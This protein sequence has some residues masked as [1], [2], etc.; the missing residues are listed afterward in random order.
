[1]K[2]PDIELM[3]YTDGE[4]DEERARRVRV[5]RLTEL[6]VGA[7]L[8]GIEQVG[9]F[10]RAW[11]AKSGVDARAERRRAERAATRRRLVGTV[12]VTLV[13]LLAVAEPMTPHAASGAL[14]VAHAPSPAV[15]IESVDFGSHSGTVF[16][17]EASGSA[18]PVVW[19]DDDAKAGG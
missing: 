16:V 3:L 12:A 9:S 1:M 8:E 13:A 6:E 2:I 7:R 15:A 19:L 10:V 14:E 18:T 11:A 17:V 5:A 4:L